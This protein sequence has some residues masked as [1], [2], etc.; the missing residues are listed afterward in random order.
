MSRAT[1][2]SVCVCLLGA[3]ST[4]T[5]ARAQSPTPSSKRPQRLVDVTLPA[6]CQSASSDSAAAK[7]LDR[8]HQVADVPGMIEAFQVQSANA[9]RSAGLGV[10]STDYVIAIKSLAT[11]GARN[12]TASLLGNCKRLLYPVIIEHKPG[13]FIAVER[14][15]S[16]WSVAETG[17][18]TY[19]A[20]VFR[21]QDSVTLALHTTR[22]RTFVV[23]IEQT[24]LSFVGVSVPKAFDLLPLATD[25]T[26]AWTQGHPLPA[27]EIFKA[28]VPFA[29]HGD[30]LRYR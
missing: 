19:A 29:L 22:R 27:K 11:Y 25:S 7:G 1:K 23:E 15:V 6:L 26:L 17:G 18:P 21:M 2:I 5:T 12:L 9:L 14:G 20:N 13:L 4:F 8:L 28:L 30:S 24:D 16:G 3:L 10:P